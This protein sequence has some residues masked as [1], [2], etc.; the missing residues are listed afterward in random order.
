MG[1]GLCY[2]RY[3]RLF[4]QTKAPAP[5]DNSNNASLTPTGYMSLYFYCGCIIQG[6]FFP[7]DGKNMINSQ[8]RFFFFKWPV[9]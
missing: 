1:S 8:S 5:N 9:L 2:W 4:I 7:G 3:R 6:C